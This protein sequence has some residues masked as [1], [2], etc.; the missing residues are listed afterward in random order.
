MNE[1]A[2]KNIRRSTTHYVAN[3]K[4]RGCVRKKMIACRF[5]TSTREH[6]KLP[7]AAGERVCG[8]A[9][10]NSRYL[11]YMAPYTQHKIERGGENRIY[12]EKFIRRAACYFLS[13]RR[14]N[15]KA[16]GPE[17]YKYTRGHKFW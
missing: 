12:W 11:R 14:Y 15:A 1:F 6:Y 3:G 5:S 2:M 7:A 4:E 8:M 16:I 13:A 9:K 17:M 10:G